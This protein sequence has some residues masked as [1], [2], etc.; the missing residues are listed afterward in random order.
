MEEQDIDTSVASS[1]STGISTPQTEI[2]DTQREINN[3]YATVSMPRADR[4]RTLSNEQDFGVPEVKTISDVSKEWTVSMPPETSRNIARKAGIYKGTGDQISAGVENV[5]T[6]VGGLGDQAKISIGNIANWASDG[7]VGQELQ[8]TAFASMEKRYADM[9]ATEGAV[10][11]IRSELAQLVSG[12]TS[13]VE[14]AAVGLATGGYGALG[15]IAV[16]SQGEGTYNDIAA[17]KAE[18]G[19]TEGYKPSGFDIAA[20]TLNT[21]LQVGIEHWLGVGSPRFLTGASRGLVKE[22]LSGAAQEAAQSALADVN[23]IVKGNQEWSSLAENADNYLRDAIIGGVL[24]GAMGAATYHSARAKS[25]TNMAN[26]IAKSGGREI[27]NKEDMQKAKKI[28][29]DKEK[30]YTAVL[31]H[32]FKNTFDAST[33]QGQLQ[34]KIAKALNDATMSED[35]D[36][37]LDET[38]KAQKIEQVATIET[39]NALADSQEKGQSIDAHAINNIVYK[40]GK[41][42]IEGLTPELGAAPV[43]DV[44]LLKEREKLNIKNGLPKVIS[45]A[46]GVKQAE[47]TMPKAKKSL[48][49]QRE[50]LNLPKITEEQIDEGL[51]MQTKPQGKGTRG[52]YD[53]QLKSIILKKDADITTVQHEF[54]HYWMDNN[55]KWYRSGLASDDWKN[56][57]RAVERALGIEENDRF[58]S[59]TESE[60]F[61]KAYE[62]YILEDKASDELKWAFDGFQKAYQETYEDLSDEYFDLNEELNPDITAWFNRQMPT[63]ASE[64]I[65]NSEVEVGKEIIRQGGSV[66]TAIDGGVAIS[67]LEGTQQAFE[68]EKL[69]GSKLA[70]KSDKKTN[71]KLQESLKNKFGDNVKVDKLQTLNTAETLNNARKWIQQDYKSAW[72][73]MLSESTNNID[74]GYLYQ[75]FAEE[76]ENNPQIA[77]D[78]TNVNMAQWARELGQATQALD[79]RSET[80]F[81]LQDV[82]KTLQKSK[83][84][85]SEQELESVIAEI[86]TEN[87]ELDQSDESD[88]ENEVECKI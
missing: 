84:T 49:A 59:K 45:V 74:R 42:Y 77:I 76:G 15:Q 10:G 57:W 39:L 51:Q 70:V 43:T 78:L 86:G 12:A 60:R 40:D 72:S 75:A 53:S 37:N 67:N 3:P 26:V 88:L 2:V 61:S 5:L 44:K 65:K 4:I 36:L 1:T 85:L 32:T 11:G 31:T 14:L 27:P 52:T 50:E 80:G 8:D 48:K 69:E 25:D 83:G 82:L 34:Q 21:T 71:S 87:I 63:T 6:S 16:Q 33:G 56:K 79:I 19:T 46:K 38:E 28:N 29:D 30:G 47:S 73:A 66:A 22:G 41:I 20:N 35:F 9:A 24:Q 23:E 64:V 17:Y 7:T 81:D 62:R 18:F 13:F 58:L 68:E 55:F 54:A